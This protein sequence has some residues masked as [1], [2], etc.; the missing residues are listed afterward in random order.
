M[1]DSENLATANF[2]GEYTTSSSD[3]VSSFLAPALDKSSHYDRAS[4][5]FSSSLFVL[6][7]TAWTSFFKSGGKMRLICS[8]QLSP[9]DFEVLAVPSDKGP[10][11]KEEFL[12]SWEELLRTER[13]TLT[14]QLLS[15]LV[16]FDKLELRVA[17]YSPGRGLFHDKLGIFSDTSGNQM[18][19]TG[20]ANETWSAWSGK[21]N[22][23]S[24]DVFRSWEDFEKDRV[25]RHKGRFEEY[26]YGRAEGLE[27]F[28]GEDLKQIIVAREPDEDLEA[29]MEK[30]R[31]ELFDQSH[32]VGPMRVKKKNLRPYQQEAVENWEVKNKGVISFATGGGKTLTAIEIIRRWTKNGGAALVLVP[33]AILIDQWINELGENL[34]NSKVLRADSKSSSWASSVN[35]FLSPDSSGQVKVVVSTYRTVASK[36]FRAIVAGNQGLLVVGDEVHR[37]GANDTKSIAE[38]LLSGG[39]LGLSATPIRQHDEEGTDSIFA[40]FGNSIEPSYSLSQAITDGNLVPYNF[41]FRTAGLSSSEQSEWN[42]LT[43]KIGKLMGSDSGLGLTKGSALESLLIARARVAKLAA[44]KLK[45]AADVVSSNFE[46][47]DRWL[48]YCETTEHVERVKAEIRALMPRTTLM[49][50]LSSNSEQHRSV[51]SHFQEQGGVLIAI[52][53]LDE[54]VDIPRINKAIIVSSSQSR[55]EF[56][57]RRGRT[58][59]KSPGKHFAYLFDFLMMDEN[60]EVLMEKELERL[61]DFAQDAFNEEPYIR[62]NSLKNTTFPIS[63][64]SKKN[65]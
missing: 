29:I 65:G 53:C 7:P 36:R 38:S 39:Q 6:A 26:W 50:Y 40:Y 8:N 54:G 55:R 43:A 14:A 24:I 17:R 2:F 12:N 4:G 35:S 37:F 3:L 31:Q 9:E 48:V 22:H 30:V 15:A 57:Q 1:T 64:V 56:I 51:M 49:T 5:Y 41:E 42:D 11:L 60:G 44:S 61:I 46:Q 13:G 25:Q 18:S 47:G 23:E 62:L 45:I 20:S 10:S 19:F 34:P 58:L 28:S 63:L 16:Y 33:T 59:R 52:R 32:E 27:V 21:G